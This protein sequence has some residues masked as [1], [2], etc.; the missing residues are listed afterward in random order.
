M[1]E[2]YGDGI[3]EPRQLLHS[4][5]FAVYGDGIWEQRQLLHSNESAVYGDSIWD[6]RH[7]VNLWHKPT[8][9]MNDFFP[10]SSLI[11]DDLTSH[12]VYD[13]TNDCVY[14]SASDQWLDR[15]QMMERDTALHST[16]YLYE[17]WELYEGFDQKCVLY[18]Q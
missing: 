2:V 4:K 16:I 5:E 14:D 7:I 18:T 17:N 15:A 10:Y 1:K 11:L 12:Y 3:W 9:V 8:S 13:F 6:P